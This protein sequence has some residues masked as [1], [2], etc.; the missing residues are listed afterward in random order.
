MLNIYEG[1]VIYEFWADKD[2]WKETR[3]CHIPGGKNSEGCEWLERT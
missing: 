3:M 2:L 1:N